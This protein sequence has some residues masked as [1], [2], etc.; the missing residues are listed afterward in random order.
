MAS[1]ILCF[2]CKF[3]FR[4]VAG[5]ISYRAFYLCITKHH[6]NLLS[7]FGLLLLLFLASSLLLL[8]L[9]LLLPML[10]LET[11]QSA[12]QV[13]DIFTQ[14]VGKVACTWG[15]SQGNQPS[16]EL[17]AGKDKRPRVTAAAAPLHG[18]QVP[19]RL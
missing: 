13:V 11:L 14:T 19:A 6:L 8:S 4:S 1:L 2:F 12:C 5:L 17:G 16:R 18:V 10:L 9:S 7:F 15:Q 3:C